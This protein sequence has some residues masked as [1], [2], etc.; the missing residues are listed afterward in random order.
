MEDTDKIIHDMGVNR[1]TLRDFN[2]QNLKVIRNI[3]H[4]YGNLFSG[5]KS[6]EKK[7]YLGIGKNLVEFDSENMKLDKKMEGSDFIYQ[8][9]K[10]REK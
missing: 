2:T 7:C 10:V 9:V 8:I 5:L 1:F 4:S 3:E 6:K